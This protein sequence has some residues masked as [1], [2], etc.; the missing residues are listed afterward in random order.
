MIS[1]L[2]TGKTKDKLP[3]LKIDPNST[4]ESHTNESRLFTCYEPSS[5]FNLVR[6]S[7]PWQTRHCRITPSEPRLT[8][9]TR[10]SNQI[11]KTEKLR[12]MQLY[13]NN[14]NYLLQKAQFEF[15]WKQPATNIDGNDFAGPGRATFQSFHPSKKTPARRALYHT[16]RKAKHTHTHTHPHT[17]QS[18]TSLIVWYKTMRGVFLIPETGN[19]LGKWLEYAIRVRPTFTLLMM[20]Q[21]PLR[22]IQ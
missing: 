19:C 14:Y 22:I 8:T 4:L 18:T 3:S 16:I 11:F 20:T 15:E 17:N 10:V 9:T 2:P 7:S 12:Y 5:K 6:Q 21:M 1:G 13:P